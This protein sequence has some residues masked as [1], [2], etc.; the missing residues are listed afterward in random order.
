LAALSPLQLAATL[1]DRALV[2]FIL[3]KQ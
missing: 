1:G 2:R 3:K